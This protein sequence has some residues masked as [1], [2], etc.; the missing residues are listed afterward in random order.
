MSELILAVDGG[1]AKTDL[2]VVSAQGEVLSLVR[3]PRPSS[4]RAAD[5]TAARPTS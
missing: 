4:E 5:Q 2:A 3:G 1:N